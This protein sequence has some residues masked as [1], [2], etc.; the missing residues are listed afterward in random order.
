M[1]HLHVSR[2]LRRAAVIALLGPA[3]TAWSRQ[4]QG[5]AWAG[6]KAG[7]RVELDVVCSGAWV[8]ATILKIEPVEGRTERD[9]T[10][11]RA[12]GSEW[13]FRAPG[14][15]APCGRAAGGI[16]RDRAA[17]PAPP[18][19]VYVCNYRGQ[20]QPVFDFALLNGSAYRNY[21]GARGTYRLDARTRQVVFVTGPMQGA[22]AQQEAAK[23]F[24]FL[25]EDGHGTGNHCAHNPAKDPNGRW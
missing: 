13:S 3:A 10:I 5:A 2:G 4:P 9:Y 14:I 12:D 25:N 22:R 18:L 24:Q 1:R 20:W 21:D 23:H 7:D 16:A 17:L 6:F 15:V 11:R 8:S 19:G